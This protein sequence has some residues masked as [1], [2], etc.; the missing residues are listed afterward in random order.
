VIR[1]LPE[2]LILVGV[3]LLEESVKGSPGLILGGTRILPRCNLQVRNEM[4]EQS[5]SLFP[6]TLKTLRAR[7]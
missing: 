5:D 6:T 2:I 4:A 1:V 7:W 3:G